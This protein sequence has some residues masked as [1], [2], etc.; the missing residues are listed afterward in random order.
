MQRG[1]QPTLLPYRSEAWV[2]PTVIQ[3]NFTDAALAVKCEDQLKRRIT[4]LRKQHP[5][6]KEEVTFKSVQITSDLQVS[7]FSVVECPQSHVHVSSAGVAV[8]S[9]CR[10]RS[11]GAASSTVCSTSLQRTC[12]SCSETNIMQL[13]LHAA[14]SCKSVQ[15]CHRNDRHRSGGSGCA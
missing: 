12:S 3:G 10:C 14:F 2:R 15:R 13:H 11:G 6:W 8:K 4:A 7:C 5:I 9:G 1:A